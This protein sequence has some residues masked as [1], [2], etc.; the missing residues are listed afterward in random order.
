M[1]NAPSIAQLQSDWF[2]LSDLIAPVPSSPS[3]SPE[4][5]SE[6]L[7]LNLCRASLCFV[8]FSKRPG[9]R[10][11][12]RSSPW[13]QDIDQRARPPRQVRGPAPPPNNKRKSLSNAL[14]NLAKRQISFAIGFFR[15]ICSDELG[16]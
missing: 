16:R 3:T 8:T 9:S 13:R 11:A 7:L 4:S 15:P 6:G 5:P 10:L 12:T 14:W 2:K 1:I